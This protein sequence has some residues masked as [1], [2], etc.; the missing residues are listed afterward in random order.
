MVRILFFHIFIHQTHFL[1]I[2]SC[3]FPPKIEMAL[4]YRHWLRSDRPALPEETPVEGNYV[5]ET[6]SWAVTC[7][8]QIHF[9]PAALN[10]MCT[11]KEYL[12]NNLDGI[13]LA[14]VKTKGTQSPCSDCPRS[15]VDDRKKESQRTNVCREKKNKLKIKPEPVIPTTHGDYSRFR[16]RPS[17]VLKHKR[18]PTLFPFR[19][20]LTWKTD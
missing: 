14:T 8:V 11:I 16:G 6:G 1:Q 7:S 3:S 13:L 9:L 12:F 18:H 2:S 4:W 17:Q 19:M 5:N 10:S 15:N 20:M